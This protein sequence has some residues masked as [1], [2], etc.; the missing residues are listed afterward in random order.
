MICVSVTEP[1]IENMVASANSSPADLVEVRL[2]C[3]DKYDGVEKL[4]GIKKP[5]IVTCM[6]VSEGGRYAG[7]EED[8]IAL[9]FDAVKYADYVS[10]ELSTKK[11][12]MDRIMY[13]AANRDAKIIVTYH[14]SKKTPDVKEIKA[15][16]G[17]EE[18]AGADIAKVAFHA[19][20]YFD[21][22]RLMG[23]LIENDLGIPVI[24]ISM[25]EYGRI[26]RILGPLF[27]SYLT[28]ASP[29]KGLE[30]APGQL[31]VEEM[32][33]ILGILGRK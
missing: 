3:L 30:S 24:A 33:T 23:V 20:D 2:D 11:E 8:R 32:Q 31:T 6:P 17:R 26:S 15:V 22:M 13:E 5:L 28:Y 21:V 16:L 9:L 29:G 10:L 25:G 18:K 12:L 14:D 1:V 4:R 19:K 7:G 27:G